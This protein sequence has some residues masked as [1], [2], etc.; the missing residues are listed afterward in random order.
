MQVAAAVGLTISKHKV[1]TNVSGKINAAKGIN[2]LANNEGNFR[3]LG[4]GVA[5]S[6]ASGS[7]SIAAAVGVSVN[8]NEANVNIAKDDN[9]TNA[10]NPEIISENGDVNVAANLTQNTTGK[11][12]GLLATQSIAGSVSGDGGASVAGAVSVL[13]SSAATKGLNQNDGTG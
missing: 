12:N 3:T 11:Y 1:N 9:E 4:T 13:V 10:S 6:L 2:I 5:M 8:R 7:N